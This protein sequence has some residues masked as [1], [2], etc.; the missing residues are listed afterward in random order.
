MLRVQL[1]SPQPQQLPPL[2]TWAD[3]KRTFVGY[4]TGTAAQQLLP[5]HRAAIATDSH[6]KIEGFSNSDDAPMMSATT[7]NCTEIEYS[8]LADCVIETDTAGKDFEF[9]ANTTYDAQLLLKQLIE[10]RKFMYR[11]DA[12][13]TFHN[14]PAPRFHDRAQYSQG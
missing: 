12:D 1:Q 9:E 7:F 6:Y 14:P 13:T 8:D 3:F 4:A 11:V 10:K 2:A 5:D